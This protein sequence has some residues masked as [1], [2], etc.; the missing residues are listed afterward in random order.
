VNGGW[1]QWYERQRFYRST[2]GVT[3]DELAAGAFTGGHPVRFAAAG[4][5]DVGTCP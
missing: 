4:A 5:V 1:D 3:W 2:D